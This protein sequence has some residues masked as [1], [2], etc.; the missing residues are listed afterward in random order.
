MTNTINKHLILK[1]PHTNNTNPNKIEVKNFYQILF[2]YN[3]PILLEFQIQI[4]T[5]LG[6]DFTN[7][8]SDF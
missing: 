2:S 7:L 1:I 8:G 4:S 5:N 6:S 3:F